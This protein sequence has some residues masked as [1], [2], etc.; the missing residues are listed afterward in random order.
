MPAPDFIRPDPQ[1]DEFEKRYK[2]MRRPDFNGGDVTM[3]RPMTKLE[4]EQYREYCRRHGR[5]LATENNE[6]QMPF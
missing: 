2:G 4:L 6:Y 5:S 3:A 1:R